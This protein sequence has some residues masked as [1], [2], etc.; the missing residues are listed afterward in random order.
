MKTSQ[1]HTAHAVF[2]NSKQNSFFYR[3]GNSIDVALGY[4]GIEGYCKDNV[5]LGCVVGRVANRIA[6][7]QFTLDNKQYQ[8]AVN[9]GP[10]HLHGGPNGFSKAIWSAEQSTNDS[11]TFKYVSVDGEESYPGQVSVTVTCTL[12]GSEI[13]L[14]YAATSL[15]PT[16]INLTNHTY[17]N[18]GGHDSGD[19]RNHIIQINSEYYTPLDDVQIPTGEITSVKGTPFDFMSPKPI[20]KNMPEGGYDHN[21]CLAECTGPCIRVTEPNSG[22]ILE[23]FTNQP[24]VQFYTANY[25]NGIEGKGGAVYNKHSGFCLETQNYPNAINQD[26]FPSCVIRP[27]GPDYKHRT[28]Y[29]FCN[30]N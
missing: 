1:Y 20:G 27:G 18:L 13:I 15:E 4:D 16:P 9:N 23:V 28:V 22:R 11:V 19:I 5:Y 3:E 2:I 29:K 26:N 17:F 7:G 30:I 8:L 14:D 24:G 21:F 6:K 10:N 25:L 12:R